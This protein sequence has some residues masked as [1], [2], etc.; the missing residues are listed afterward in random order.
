MNSQL[1]SYWLQRAAFEG[2]FR[3]ATIYWARHYFYMELQGET[4]DGIPF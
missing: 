1:A 3:L 4:S 2:N